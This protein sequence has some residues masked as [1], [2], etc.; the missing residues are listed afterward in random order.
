MSTIK[1]QKIQPPNTSSPL[2]IFTNDIEAMRVT[3][4]GNVGIGATGPEAR[5]EVKSGQSPVLEVHST[6]AGIAATSAVVFNRN[7]V[8]CGYFQF[9]GTTVELYYS[10]DYR[11]KNNVEPLI[12]ALDKICE[13][14]PV[15]FNWINGDLPDTGFIAHEVQS[16]IPNAVNG[17]KD[18]VNHDGSILIQSMT[19]DKFI[20]WLVA[21]M[22]E[23]KAIVDTQSSEIAAL[24]AQMSI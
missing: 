11:L 20:A 19:N 9:Y 4:G 3:A 13:L 16:V 15:S 2:Q 12:G 24:K 22:K 17:E 23:L 18:A 1:A 10:S 14:N 8:Q 21:G 5:L 7:S 6:V